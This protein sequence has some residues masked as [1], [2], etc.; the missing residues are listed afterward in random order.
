MGRSGET[1]QG[2][3]ADE[4]RFA[5]DVHGEQGGSFRDWRQ[6]Q[7]TLRGGFFGIEGDLSAV[8]VSSDFHPAQDGVV[9]AAQLQGV[10]VCC[11]VCKTSVDFV[12]AFGLNRSECVKAEKRNLLK[13]R[14]SDL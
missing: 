4:C 9:P 7:I 11:V 5:D 12:I 8:N 1:S 6:L 14:V 13:H 2:R 3:L 10:Q